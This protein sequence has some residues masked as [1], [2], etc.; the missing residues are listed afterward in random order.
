MQHH[1][2]QHFSSQTLEEPITT[3]PVSLEPVQTWP[4]LDEPVQGFPEGP[5]G[6]QEPSNGPGIF[7]FSGIEA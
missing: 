1:H 7:H 5:I 2:H 4:V 3:Q 6:V